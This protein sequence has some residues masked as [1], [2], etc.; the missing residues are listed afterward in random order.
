MKR[1]DGE[2][3]GVE[4]PPGWG[5]RRGDK[6]AGR[7]HHYQVTVE[8]TGNDGSGTASYRSYGRDHLVRAD[9][10]P[11][12]P[13]SAEPVFRGDP[14]RYNPEELLVA[15][16]SQCH[17]LWYLHLCADA[18][19]VVEAYLDAATGAME[20]L[21]D[22]GGAFTEVVLRPRVVIRD[23]SKTEQALELHQE[24]RRRCFVAA[25]VAFPVRC[26]PVIESRRDDG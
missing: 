22:G 25:S 5:R 7:R 6:A 1:R 14:S 8:W 3:D 19:L 20:E 23:E 12:L 10:K 11:D 26:E 15:S 17:M 21:P 16:I 13:G 18:G 24:A 2:G 9:G 4:E